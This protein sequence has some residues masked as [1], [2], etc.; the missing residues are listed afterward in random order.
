[1]DFHAVYIYEYVFATG[2]HIFAMISH[3]SQYSFLLPMLETYAIRIKKIHAG[4]LS[5]GAVEKLTQKQ[6]LKRGL[7]RGKIEGATTHNPLPRKCARVH[8][9]TFLFSFFLSQAFSLTKSATCDTS[10]NCQ[11]ME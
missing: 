8:T 11:K 3:L 5:P 2:E 4:P 1:M 10:Q 9:H 6:H 7:I